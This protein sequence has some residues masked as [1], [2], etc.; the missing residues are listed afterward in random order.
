MVL[1]SLINPQKAEKIP[2]RMILFGF[3]YASIA[4]GIGLWVFYSYASMLFVFLAAIAAVPLMYNTI[5]HEEEKD[6]QDLS[7][8]L[9]LKEHTKALSFFM[10]LF[11]GLTLACVFWYTILPSATVSTLFESQTNTINTINGN[12]T[13]FFSMESFQAF[14]KVFLNNIKVMIFCAIFSL[15]YGA[16]AIFIMSWNASVIGAAIGNFIRGN[17]ASYADHIG[18]DKAAQYMS[19]ISIGLL[20][21]VIH[22]VP[23]I[24]AYFTAGLAGGI[25]SIAIIRHDFGT[26]KFEHILL[27]SADLFLLSIGMIFVAAVLEVWITPLIF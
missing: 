4:I 19:V 1:E 10:Y 25:I 23:E 21:Y 26:R 24:L 14:T 9:L 15:L 5:K 17:L 22:G 6:T 16:G 8:K 11:L 3:I 7:E 27:D 20:K 13:G 18:L 2:V 12:I